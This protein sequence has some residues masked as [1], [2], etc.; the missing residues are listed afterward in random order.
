MEPDITN[1]EEEADPVASNA[2]DEK[3]DS[4][5]FV[6]SPLEGVVMKTWGQLLNIG[7]WNCRTLHKPGKLDNLIQELNHMKI[8]IMGIAETRWTV[9][10]KIVKDDYNMIYSGGED[11]KNEVGIILRNEVAKSL[12]GYWPTSDRVVMVKLQAKPFNINMIQVYA[13]TQDYDGET[14]E[15]FYEQIQS[16]VSYTKSSDI[17]CIMGYLNAKIGNVKDS[18]IISNYGLDKQ[19]ERGQ[20]LMEFCNENN[21]VIMNTW[22]Q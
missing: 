13:P 11:H 1:R 20:R 18:K 21:M 5:P 15:E 16:A 2:M 8:N 6:Q 4:N 3:G 14:I 10:G 19:N 12:I 9:T 17:I 7:T 22:F